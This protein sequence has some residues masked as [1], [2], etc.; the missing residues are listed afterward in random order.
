MRW[1]ILMYING[2]VKS[3][4]KDRAIGVGNEGNDWFG[5]DQDVLFPA[6]RGWLSG[7]V[8]PMHWPNLHDLT[9]KRSPAAQLTM[10]P[11][12]LAA[13]LH[14]GVY[15]HLDSSRHDTLALCAQRQQQPWLEFTAGTTLIPHGVH[16]SPN[17]RYL[18]WGNQRGT[19][20]VADLKAL[21]QQLEVFAKTLPD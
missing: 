17:G 3:R 18:A 11:C 13:G 1:C 12:A 6:L 4:R 21:E 19:V 20:M 16:F 15:R 7:T 10:F 14:W 9:Q 8:S 5:Q 2:S